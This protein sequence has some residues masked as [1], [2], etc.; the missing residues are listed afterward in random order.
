MNVLDR[1]LAL[2]QEALNEFDDPNYRLSNI[3]RKAIRIARLRNDYDNLWWLEYEMIPFE[4]R[5]AQERIVWEILPHYS[6][7]RFA[8]VQKHILEAYIDERRYREVDRYGNVVDKGNVRIESI[9]EIEARVEHLDDVAEKAVVPEGLHPVDLYF[10]EQSKSQ[11]RTTAQLLAQDLRAILAR[12]GQ[13]VHEFLSVTEKQLMYGQIS[14]D[15]FERNR[16]YVDARLHD[17]APEALEQF[18]AA[19]RRLGEGGPE[20]GSHALTSCRR[21]LKSVADNIYPARDEPVVGSDGKERRLTDDKFVSRLW[22]F[23]AERVGGSAS[24]RL[25]LTSVKDVGDR[26]D[27]IYD[28]SCKGVHAEVSE[29]EVNQCVIQTYLLIGDILRI[30]DQDSAVGAETEIAA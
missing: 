14:S 28:L 23:V 21:I 2:V 1:I 8:A 10:V 15:I 30:A 11:L 16:Q 3:M 13:R 18:I 6:K 5:D 20:S 27:R 26:I 7:D 9:S 29:F 17:I 12:V 22:Q 25:L 19:Y 4:N 24:G